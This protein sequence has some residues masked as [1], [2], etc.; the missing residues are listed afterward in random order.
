MLAFEEE[1]QLCMARIQ[2]I[3]PKPSDQVPHSSHKSCSVTVALL[4]AR[5]VCL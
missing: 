5:Y 4:V 2:E 3:G 1:L